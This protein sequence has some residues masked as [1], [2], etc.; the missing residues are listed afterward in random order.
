M[1]E[2]L[3]IILL[4]IPLIAGAIAIFFSFQLMKRYDVSFATSYFYYLVF[5]YIFGVYSLAGSGILEHL[6]TQ[7]EIE[8]K[9]I[10]SARLFTIFIGI[11]FLALS[12]FMLLRSILEFYQKRVSAT[13]TISYFVISIIAFFTYGTFVVRLTRFELGEYQLLITIQRWVFTGFMV[14]MYLVIFSVVIFRSR[15]MPDHYEKRFI[16]VFASWYLLFMM[17]CCAAFALITL[18][19]IVPYIFIFIFLSWH[20]IP[21]LFLSLYLEKYHRQS[22]SLQN[23]F[24]TKLAAFSTKFEISKRECEVIQLICKGQ[25]NQEIGDA[26]YISLQTVKDHIHRIFVK[27]GVKNRIQL[28]NLIRSGS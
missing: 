12:V 17:V 26:L 7:M 6:L 2:P 28:T 24:E 11:P 19:E 27:S 16:R 4:F 3:R 22:S 13:I 21:I 10:H 1:G 20:L 5:L 15:K 25:T 18:H 8:L 9:V 14:I 23:D